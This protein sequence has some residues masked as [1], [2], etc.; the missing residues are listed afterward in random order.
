MDEKLEKKIHNLEE[1]IIGAHRFDTELFKK[2]DKAQ[3]ELG[4]LDDGRPFCPFLR[5]HFFTRRKY[6]QITRAAEVL[7]GAFERL[8]LAALENRELLAEFDLTE[9]EEEMARIDPGYPGVCNSSRFDTFISG[10]DF[11]FLEY[12]GETPAGITDQMQ[13]EKVLEMIPEVRE[14]LA[15]N[16]HWRP[17]PHEKLLDALV[18]GYRDFGGKKAKPNIAVV[19]WKEV[20]TFSEFVVLQEFFESKGF[21][22][23]ICDPHELE[24]DGKTLRAGEFEIDIFYKRVLIHEYQETFSADNALANAYRDGNIFMANSYRTKIPHKKASLAIVQ[25]EKNARLFSD[26][27]LE[28]IKKHIP[29]TRKVQETKTDFEGK[30]IDLIEHLRREKEKFLLKPNDGSGIVL[31]W[32]SSESEWETAL[33]DALQNSFVA[34]QRAPVEKVKIPT[35]SDEIKMA[36]LLIDFDPFLFR[37]RAEGGLVRLS[38]SSLVNIAQGGGETALIVLE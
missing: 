21:P 34:Q 3:R 12:N 37:G 6:E 14:F 22:A 29:W 1:N 15:G 17:A 31:G 4:I 20:K 2:L 9:R 28:M 18:S 30:E 38:S 33:Q 19:D 32:E 13:I 35:Y 24:Y 8:T 11:K 36:E 10:E 26:E 27:Q 23:K 16:K 7:A 5:P 25:D